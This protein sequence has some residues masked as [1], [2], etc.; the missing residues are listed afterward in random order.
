[1]RIFLCAA[2]SMLIYVFPALSSDNQLTSIDIP[3]D[4]AINEFYIEKIMKLSNKDEI[5][6]F[7]FI[8]HKFRNNQESE[9]IT[10]V[11]FVGGKAKLGNLISIVVNCYVNN[12]S[13]SVGTTTVVG[14]DDDFIYITN[15]NIKQGL[16]IKLK[17]MIFD[18]LISVVRI[19]KFPIS[20]FKYQDLSGQL[21][22][23]GIFDE[24]ERSDNNMLVLKVK[25]ET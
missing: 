18:K 12:Q 21:N 10:R 8:D 6:T 13:S 7:R 16:D 22:S 19:F 4:G 3:D 17:K 11:S 24:S 14:D 15:I 23:I 1:M 9:I 2:L 20:C 5:F 25:S